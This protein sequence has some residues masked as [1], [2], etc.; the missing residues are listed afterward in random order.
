[1]VVLVVISCLF[2]SL[3]WFWFLIVGLLLMC[4]HV[5]SR[6]MFVDG[7]LFVVVCSLLIV[8][9]LLLCVFCCL[10]FAVC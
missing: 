9:C 5:C 3:D 2:L 10:W 8:V 1:M 6:L 7:C 4:V